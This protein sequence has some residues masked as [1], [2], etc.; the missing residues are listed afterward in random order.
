MI[1]GQAAVPRARG[2]NFTGLEVAHI[3][4]LMGVGDVG[5][6]CLVSSLIKVSS[7]AACLDNWYGG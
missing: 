6:L 5:T 3:F 7:A 1:T 4:P 2:T